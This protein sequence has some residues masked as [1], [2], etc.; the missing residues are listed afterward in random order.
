[1]ENTLET[2][3]KNLREIEK[4]LKDFLENDLLYQEDTH[5]NILMRRQEVVDRCL[6]IRG[7]M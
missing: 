1:M 4:E 7:E 3:T 6:S 2:A 5:Q